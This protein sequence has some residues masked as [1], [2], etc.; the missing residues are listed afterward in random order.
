MDKKKDKREVVAIKIF[1]LLLI[2]YIVLFISKS[3]GYSEYHAHKQVELNEATMKKLEDD[4][5]KGKDVTLTDYIKERDI[6]YNNKA[7]D[8]GYSMSKEIG[9]IISNG[10]DSTMSFLGELFNG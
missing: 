8:I 10:L 4:V 1:Y 3:S 5:K 7:S 9:Y 6:K 2:S